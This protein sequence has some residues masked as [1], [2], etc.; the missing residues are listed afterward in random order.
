MP[1]SGSQEPQGL[2]FTPITNRAMRIFGELVR[3][4]VSA[5][6]KAAREQ[7]DGS[8]LLDRDA[9]VQLLRD[10]GLTDTASPGSD[11]D[12]EIRS[13]VKEIELKPRRQERF[14]VLLPEYDNLTKRTSLRVPAIYG[15]VD[16]ATV[17]GVPDDNTPARA[18]KYFRD[19]AELD[20]FLNPYM[21]AYICSQCA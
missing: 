2:Q 19:E 6:P 1:Y 21:A 15:L 5:P 9:F 14:T 12:F 3:E 16:Y 11:P 4:W 17:G 7:A 8:Y 20:A 10:R 18:S 13:D